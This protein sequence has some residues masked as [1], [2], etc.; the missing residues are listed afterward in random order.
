[1]GVNRVEGWL[2]TPSAMRG[3]SLINSWE[4]CIGAWVA[5]HDGDQI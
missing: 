4:D 1:M 5:T 2:R 3:L